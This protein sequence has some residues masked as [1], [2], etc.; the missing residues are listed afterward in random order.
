MP[1]IAMLKMACCKDINRKKNP[2]IVPFGAMPG[3][4]I[5]QL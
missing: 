2:G 1:Y 4:Q 5:C 3:L